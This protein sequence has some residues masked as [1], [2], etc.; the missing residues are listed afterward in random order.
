MDEII[1]S[2]NAFKTM[3]EL[4]TDRNYDVPNE[5]KQ[6]DYDTYK[7]IYEN[8]NNDIYCS[9]HKIFQ[10]KKIYIKF[11]QTSKIKPNYI[12][13]IINTIITE[14][15]QNC[16]YEIIIVLKNKPNNSILKVTKEKEFKHC[17][18]S[19]LNKLQFNI[20]KH[21]LVPSHIEIDKN[22]LNDLLS[23]YNI[24]NIYQ[25]PIILKEDPI[26]KYYNFKVGSVIKIIRASETSGKHIF[27]RCV[28]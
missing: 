24:E 20:T 5:Y 22:E 3:L 15:L 17:D 23:R 19:W 18:I 4:C 13:E 9:K 10:K 6:I 21:K 16:D 28:K 26:V 12:R 11:I 14:Y 2:F 27:Y 8:K 7:Y 25:L 1:L